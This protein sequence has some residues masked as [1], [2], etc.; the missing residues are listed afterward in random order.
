MVS[1]L[2][3]IKT[4]EEFLFALGSALATCVP[5]VVAGRPGQV[6]GEGV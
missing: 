4:C 5:G 3:L 6:P 2:Q 1:I